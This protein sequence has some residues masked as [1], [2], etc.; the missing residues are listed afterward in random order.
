[1]YNIN[2]DEHDIEA[3]REKLVFLIGAATPI[4]EMATADLVA[5]ETCSPY[6]VI[7]MAL[8]YGFGIDNYRN[9]RK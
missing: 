7:I 6:D 1:M 5:A 4:E 8:E 9:Y 2:P 3:I